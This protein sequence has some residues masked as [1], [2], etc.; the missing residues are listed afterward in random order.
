MYGVQIRYP[1]HH[2]SA[3]KLASMRLEVDTIGDNFLAYLIE[4]CPDVAWC[5]PV[6]LRR[7][8]QE[9]FSQLPGEQKT[10][11]DPRAALFLSQVISPPVWLDC[12]ALKRGQRVYL[13]YNISAH[14]GLLYY[15]L[16]GGFSA[17]KITAVLDA[18][19][20]L[21]RGQDAVW[22]RLLETLEMVVD[23]MGED[24]ALD[25]GNRGFVSVVYVRMLHSRVRRRLLYSK[26]WDE[27][28]NGLPINQADMLVTLLSFSINVLAVVSK[29]GA[30]FLT[31]QEEQDYLHLWRFI[32]LLIGVEPQNLDMHVS[33]LEAARGAL[34]SLVVDLVR[35]TSRSQVITNNILQAVSMRPP[36]R[37]SHGVHCHLAR[38][39][40][41][42][43][44]AD[45]LAIPPPATISATLTG[46]LVLFGALLGNILGP[47]FLDVTAVR[48][49]IRALLKCMLFAS[50]PTTSGPGSGGGATCPFS[51][52]LNNAD[53]ERHL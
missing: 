49:K 30:P 50:I 53:S 29:I 7:Y 44:L 2:I 28:T 15:S 48:R 42:S 34:E 22:R 6:T 32:G 5:S 36:I 27:V 11:P 51:P 24:D 10:P 45:A 18:T 41:G 35:P 1:Q 23:C 17:P 20:Y 38:V 16:V 12:A 31:R 13:K 47:L 39:L 3:D 4:V 26:G 14:L 25:V 40:L 9:F 46:W 21:T 8:I 43:E 19:G 33:S 52:L 37:L